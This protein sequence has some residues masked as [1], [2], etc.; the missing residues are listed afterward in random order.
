MATQKRR[1]TETRTHQSVKA[2]SQKKKDINWTKIIAIIV[3]V[4][5]VAS[6]LLSLFIVPGSTGF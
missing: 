5:I 2:A 1:T 3:G 6:M 4:L